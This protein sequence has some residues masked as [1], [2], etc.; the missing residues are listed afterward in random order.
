MLSKYCSI[1]HIANTWE[2]KV[3]NLLKRYLRSRKAGAGV[4]GGMGCLRKA[5][6]L[7]EEREEQLLLPLLSNHW[8]ESHALTDF[9]FPAL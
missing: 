3:G 7:R 1:Q 5:C 6:L 9:F 8:G 4:A 2:E